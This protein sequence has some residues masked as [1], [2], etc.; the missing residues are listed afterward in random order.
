MQYRMAPPPGLVIEEVVLG[1]STQVEDAELRAD[2]GP[3]VG[4]GLAA[5]IKPGPGKTAGQVLARGIKLP[6]LLGELGPVG[7]VYIICAHP[8]ADLVSLVHDAG[9]ERAGCLRSDQGL[10]RVLAM[11]GVDRLQVVVESLD[12]QRARNAGAV[13]AIDGG[14]AQA[15]LVVLV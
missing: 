6:P 9:A 7:L 2:G 14:C 13:G 11:I 10:L 4:G 5:I 15:G 8:V 12:L 1:E 3:A